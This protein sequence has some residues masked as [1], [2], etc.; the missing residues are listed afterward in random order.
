MTD[1]QEFSYE[2][3]AHADTVIR[4]RAISLDW[5]RRVLEYP[6]LIEPDSSDAELRHALARIDE[7]EGRV[8]RVIY[9][10]RTSPWRIVTAY[11]D[12]TMRNRL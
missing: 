2:L 9:N 11:F 3:T 12:R 10:Y 8:L 6:E 7:H 5:I 4:E 1:P